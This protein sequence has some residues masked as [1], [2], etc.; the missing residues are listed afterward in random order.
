METCKNITAILSKK[1][2]TATKKLTHEHLR[3]G[4]KIVLDQNQCNSS[5]I[6]QIPSKF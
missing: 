4:Y 6:N 5:N 1:V 2:T 3:V